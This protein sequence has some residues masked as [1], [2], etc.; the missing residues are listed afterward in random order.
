MKPTTNM[1]HTKLLGILLLSALP[2]SRGIAVDSNPATALKP[3]GALTLESAKVPEAPP[4]PPKPTVRL[5]DITALDFKNG[6]GE[7]TASQS[8]SGGVLKING[9]T[10]DSG[11]GAHAPAL[12]VYGV[13]TGAS[14]FVAVVGLDDAKRNDA[15]SSV[16]FQVFGDVKEMG[17]KPVLIAESP[18]LSDQTIRSWAFNLEL[19]SRFKEIQL[20]VTDAGDGNKA[21][22]ADWVDAGFI[23]PPTSP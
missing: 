4:T 18:V 3:E 2:V 15:R 21:D 1:N 19:N 5:D 6:W 11:I 16:V 20:V 23:C 10:Y 9:E 14:R 12:S 17:E 7:P 13:P 8:I 22:H